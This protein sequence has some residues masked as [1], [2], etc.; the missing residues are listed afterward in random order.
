MGIMRSMGKGNGILRAVFVGFS[1]LLQ[2]GWILLT[3]IE[4]NQF[5]TVI[6]LCSSVLASLAVL[7]LCSRNTNSAMKMPWILLIMALPVMGLSLYLL[8]EVMGTSRSIEKRLTG[9]RKEMSVYLPQS[10]Q[11]MEEMEC[12]GADF[13]NQGRYLL[14]HGG[15]PVYQNTRTEYYSEAAEAFSAM[16][17][18]LDQARD[19]IFME[20]FIVDDEQ[21][22]QQLRDILTR[23][24][25]QGVEVR[26]LYDDFGSIG[27]VDLPFARQ[28]NREGIQCMAF[29]PARPFLN[30]FMN[31]RDHRKITVIDGEI[32]FT[33]GYNLANEY[34]GLSHPYGQ[35]KDTGLRLEGEAV[36]SLTA[37]FLE[38]W[39]VTTRRNSDY[40]RYLSVT[41]C[42]PSQG[43]VQ[44]FGEDPLDEEPTAEN[45]YLNMINQAD[46]CL[47]MMTPYLIIT[48]EMSRALGLAA[49]R[50]V[51]VRII[52]PGI[53]DK[54]TVYQLT[55][56]YYSVLAR[57][58]VRIYEY[59]PGFCH[60]KQC[61][62]DGR[63]ASIGTSNL[64]FRS[65][66]L[67][68]EN[69]VLLYHCP[70][71]EAMGADFQKTFTQCREVTAQYRDGRPAMLRIWQCILRLFAPLM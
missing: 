16:K 46:R 7:R 11:A 27:Y 60:G 13:A 29:N 69:N 62:C 8:C 37:T 42:V 66:Y 44:P 49:K 10:S 5:S 17:E 39:D 23:K 56:S 64:D 45:V 12:Y 53:P 48:D 32:G 2:V 26:L 24:A 57:Q 35:W 31:H 47:Y 1:L 67:H 25:A 21:A 59:T 63:L 51:D 58:G 70:A 15:S 52:T 30:L 38:L 61:Y 50:G 4:L 28:L 34:F 40:A 14:N 6:S 9:I 41:H 19:F 65:L 43:L 18:A 68:F 36:R 20:Y 71:V 33:G 54:K 55:R 22:F 3:I